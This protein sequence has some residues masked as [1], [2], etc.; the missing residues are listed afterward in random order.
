MEKFIEK[1]INDNSLNTDLSSKITKYVD[2]SDF[3]LRLLKIIKD[4]NNK[5]TD[6]S[7]YSL[8]LK[9]KFIRIIFTIN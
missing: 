7:L 4:D 2:V 8:S 5:T 1:Y 9:K 3:I 6:Q